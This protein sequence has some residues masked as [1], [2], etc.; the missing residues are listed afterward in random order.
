[1][2]KIILITSVLALSGCAVRF[3]P[4]VNTPKVIDTPP[5]GKV[6]TA[7][8]GDHLLQKGE[9]VEEEVLTV[10]TPVDGVLY[11]V[12]PGSYPQFGAVDGEK[13]YSAAGVVKSPFAD[14]FMGL[15]T[16]PQNPG[17]VCVITTFSAR[18][19]Y[20][21]AFETS[22]QASTRAASFQQT[23]I[24]NG[25]VGNRINI[26][27]REFSNNLARPAFNNNVEYDLSS[28]STIGY[29]GASIEVIKAD[30][31]SITY[32]VISTFQ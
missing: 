14:P 19:C 27:Y 12:M 30:N 18:V 5:I 28:S 15:S 21:A 6:V 11:D 8:I 29:K 23:L 7:Q 17:Q 20:D 9:V 3:N 13:L 25:R 32:R 4:I 26:G 2:R 10:R 22:M 31:S 1:M 16:R 24:Y